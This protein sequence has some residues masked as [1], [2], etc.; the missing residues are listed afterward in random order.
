MLVNTLP[1]RA[2]D[3]II[4]QHQHETDADTRRR[5]S[6]G[7]RPMALSA[8]IMTGGVEVDPQTRRQC[9]DSSRGDR[10]LLGCR[11]QWLRWPVSHLSS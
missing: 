6:D 8:G 5:V 2:S 1:Q 4:K 11:W 3:V 10:G 9:R 7:G